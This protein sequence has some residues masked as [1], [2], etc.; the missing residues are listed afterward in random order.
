MNSKTA[1][2]KTN[3]DE[4]RRAA[5]RGPV[6]AP[7]EKL[8]TH[9]VS[10][11]LSTDELARLDDLRGPVKMQRGEYLRAAALHILPS[12]IPEINQ[13]AWVELARAAGNINQIAHSINSSRHG[14]RPTPLVGEIQKSL[15]EFRMALL[16]A[17]G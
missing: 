11:R 6:P 16:G 10:T 14:G 2:R 17:A 12:T 8:R 4:S 5:R 13:I 9:H 3:I 15:H 7:A 1:A